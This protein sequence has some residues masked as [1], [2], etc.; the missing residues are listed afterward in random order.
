MKARFLTAAAAA[1]AVAA[2]AIAAGAAPAQ[3]APRPAQRDWTANVVATP[4][5]GIRIGNP[6]ARV[7]VIEY[8]SFVC[9]H[10]AH[11]AEEGTPALLRDHVRTGR[12]SLEVRNY[13]LNG[14][15]VAATMLARCATP[16]NY[17]RFGD[18]LLSTQSQW[19]GRVQAIPPAQRQEMMAMS[20]PDRLTRIAETGGL[21]ETAARFGLP[22]AQARRCLAD[23]AAFNR[24]GEI[25]QAA[26]ALGVQGTPTFLINGAVQE[27][28]DWPSIQQRIRQAG[29]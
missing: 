8:L 2:L 17:L 10:C 15:D 7:K 11:F 3:E 12:V 1:A 6:E 9:P 23:T 4:E 24:L 22:A 18:R 29:G 25:R 14:T 13:I 26:A 5:G 27:V 28:N 16:A 19:V 20:V 21:I